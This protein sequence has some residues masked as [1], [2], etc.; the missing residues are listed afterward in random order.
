MLPSPETQF[1]PE[2]VK[3][4]WCVERGDSGHLAAAFEP[5]G[6]TWVWVKIKPPGDRRFWSMLPVTRVLFWVPIFDPQPHEQHV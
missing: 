1:H 2:R 5:I 4:G 6:K 3:W